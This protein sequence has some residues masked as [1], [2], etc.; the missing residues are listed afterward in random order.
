MDNTVKLKLSA[1]WAAVIFAWASFA[2]ASP[3]V[4][5]SQTAEPEATQSSINTPV[6]SIVVF[7]NKSR[8]VST[9]PFYK[10]SLA[11]TAIADITPLNDHS[12]YITGKQIG[13]TNISMFDKNMQLVEVVDLEVTESSQ[14]S[15]VVAVNKSRTVSF[16]LP[17]KT[18]AVAALE[19]AEITAI[20][21][22]SLYIVGKTVGTTDISVFDK[23]MQ[24]VEA[25]DLEVTKSSQSSNASSVPPIVV[26]VNKSRTV[27]FTLPFKTAAVAGNCRD[28][29]DC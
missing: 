25:V 28:N 27:S 22:R 16:T 2:I 3:T 6:R 20:T 19:I 11:S 5:S 21:D 10:A 29:A 13:T 12:L 7:V 26:A 24:L 4:V 23:N 1:K 8:T 15:I 17:F 14:S 18:V 9:K